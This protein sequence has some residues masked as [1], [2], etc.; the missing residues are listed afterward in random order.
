M[1]TTTLTSRNATLTYPN[2]V[3]FMHSPQPVIYKTTASQGELLYL[4]VFNDATEKFYREKRRCPDPVSQGD[5]VTVEFDISRALQQLSPDIDTL[6]HGLDYSGCKSLGTEL[7]VQLRDSSLHSIHNFTI[8]ALPGAL[9]AGETYNSNRRVRLYPNWPQTVTVGRPSAG[10]TFGG[11]TVAKGAKSYTASGMTGPTSEA[12]LVQ[13]I[14]D[15]SGTSDLNKLLAGIDPG[16]QCYETTQEAG[17]LQYSGWAVRPFTVDT[18]PMSSGRYFLRWLS[19][20][21][22][23]RY[24]L[25]YGGDYKFAASAAISFTRRY[26]GD[27]NMPDNRCYRNEFKANMVAGR[28]MTLG[29]PAVTDDEFELLTDLTVSPVVDLLTGMSLTAPTWTRVAVAAGT[30]TRNRRRAN[31]NLQDFEI[32]VTLPA[33]NCINL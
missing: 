7:G 24:W 28:T 2:A 33:L 12:A 8:W 1:R 4:D 18:T 26:T 11:T 22:G 23:V 10:G 16:L 14:R 19:R 15:Q 5:E 31:P 29:A 6:L 3:V 27:P 21:G 17:W 32:T 30:H 13:L 20:S 25:F 9:D